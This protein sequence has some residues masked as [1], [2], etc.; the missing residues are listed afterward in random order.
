MY[1]C[2]YGRKKKEEKR[3][4]GGGEVVYTEMEN[5]ET[6][7]PEVGIARESKKKERNETY[8]DFGG[9]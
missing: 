1:V 9:L 4:R 8:E 6:L 7:E 3:Y 2:M 5:R